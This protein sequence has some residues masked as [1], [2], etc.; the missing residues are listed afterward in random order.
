MATCGAKRTVRYIELTAFE[1]TRP[2][3]APSRAA[4]A[5]GICVLSTAPTNP[6]VSATPSYNG[7]RA[8]QR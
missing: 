4:V 3:G 6:K 7:L 1:G 2:P 8:P 5:G